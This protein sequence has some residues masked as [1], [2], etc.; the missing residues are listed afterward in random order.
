MD[1]CILYAYNHINNARI[2][3]TMPQIIEKEV[4]HV[5]YLK[6]K[7]CFHNMMWRPSWISAFHIPAISQITP[8]SD[9]AYQR[10]YKK[11][12][13]TPTWHKYEKSEVFTKR[14]G[15][16]LGFWAVTWKAQGEHLETLVILTWEALKNICAK[17]QLSLFFFQVALVIWLMLLG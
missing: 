4:L 9:L 5:V 1:F 16:H 12:Y 7:W 11:R 10:T 17:I 15:G 6:G 13:Y 3:F 8:E 14:G 2:G